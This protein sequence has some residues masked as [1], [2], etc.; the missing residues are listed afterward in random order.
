MFGGS[1][2]RALGLYPFKI[3]LVVVN[4]RRHLLLGATFALP[5]RAIVA[6]ATFA[7]TTFST[8]TATA[9]LLFGAFTAARSTAHLELGSTTK[10]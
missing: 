10:L 6:T 9:L 5:V 2:P 8:S 4:A 1:H 7:A 3:A